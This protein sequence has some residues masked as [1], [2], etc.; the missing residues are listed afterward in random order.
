V[1]LVEIEAAGAPP[2]VE[3]RRV[4]RYRWVEAAHRLDAA[5]DVGD[6]DRLLR[7][8]P[9][10]A[11]TVMRLTLAGAL[12]LSALAELDAR[13]AQLEAAMLWLEVEREELEVRPDAE[14][15]ERIDFD[16]VLRQASDRLAAMGRDGALPAADR[17]VAADALMEL[18]LRTAARGGGR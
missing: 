16:G 5:S 9:D 7:R 18:Y 1:L 4:G 8:T 10:L 15:L 6:F 17:S 12:S 2:K 13:L 14:D 11:S 3:P